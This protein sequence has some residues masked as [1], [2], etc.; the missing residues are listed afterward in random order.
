MI[1]TI[2]SG[3][4]QAI[5]HCLKVK[6][7]EKI[8]IITDKATENVGEALKKVAEALTNN[9]TYFVMENFGE[10]PF[11]FPEEIKAALSNADVSIYA[12]KAVKGELE[13]FRKPM[14]GLI[15]RLEVRHAHMP[16]ITSELMKQGMNTDYRE[17]QRVSKIVYEKVK[18]AKEIRVLTEKGTDIIAKFSKEIKWDISDGDIKPKRW[19]NLPDGEVFTS[20]ETIDGYAVIDGCLGDFFTKKYGLI[21]KT[22]LEFE[23]KNGRVVKESIRCKNK[24]LQD[25]FSEYISKDQNS[26]RI[27]EFALGTN[28][29]LKN[30][31]GNLLQDE[32]FPSVH[33][34]CGDPLPEKTG[35]KW[36]SSIHVD[37]V[38]KETTVFVDDVKIMENGKYLL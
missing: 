18:D 32:K 22:P 17:V 3:A 37:G 33:I 20:P 29:G 13:T 38:I 27:G 8:V 12:A 6:K 14:L 24:K 26:N 28:I 16:G 19:H 34:A 36:G 2:K 15:G 23:I 1:G 30:L 7:D 11:K 10:R 9:I 25:E 5:K 31:V 21:E 35:A 4:E